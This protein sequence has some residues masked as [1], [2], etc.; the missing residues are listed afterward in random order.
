MDW[1]KRL[2]LDGLGAM[3][4]LYLLLPVG[5]I[6]IVF[7][8]VRF[9][10]MGAAV[11]CLLFLAIGMSY[12]INHP[13][14]SYLF[15][16][17][18]NYFLMGASR[19]VTI[20]LV[21]TI[22]DILLLFILACVLFKSTYT[23]LEWK[24]TRNLLTLCAVIWTLFC[25]LQ[26]FNP[27]SRSNQSWFANVRATATYFMLVVVLVPVLLNKM[28]D[29]KAIL[30]IWSVLTICAVLKAYFQKSIGFDFAEARWL[31]Q[32]GSSTHII[33]TGIRYFSFFTDAANYGAGMGFSFVV[34]FIY[35]IYVKKR[36]LKIYYAIVGLMAA[37]GMI[38]SGTRS[39]LVVPLA[40]FGIFMFLSK[41]IK[42]VL[43]VVLS[44]AIV[45]CFLK[46]TTIGHGQS[47]I[48]RMRSLFNSKDASRNLRA[49]NQELIRAY[50]ADKPFGVGIG[51]GGGKALQYTPNSYIATIATDSWFVVLWVETGI[52]GLILYLS[53]F[54]VAIIY[55]SYICLFRIRNDELRG[56]LS[57]I[58]A[59]VAGMLIASS[60]NETFAQFPNGII[61]YTFFTFV[62]IGPVI[63]KKITEE[64]NKE[65]EVL[66]E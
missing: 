33:A 41:N 7:A 6:A 34:F 1:I 39:A 26:L 9:G 38:I 2:G 64:E 60:S 45:V 20:P 35:S 30:M 46:F 51:L 37:Y 40:S 44:L 24:N 32:G 65:K 4:S 47:E 62:F 58:V 5:I 18:V 48:R 53:I 36:S 57:A 22:M 19:Y 43:A 16:F 8:I 10:V 12:L 42:V 25:I 14:K 23:K 31:A 55:G 28:K 63:D 15:A 17:V 52:V 29:V 61:I 13:D 54:G 49:Q 56:C 3:A 59:G 50:M 11:S 66:N 21:G 27:N